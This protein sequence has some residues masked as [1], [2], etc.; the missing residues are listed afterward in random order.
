MINNYTKRLF[1]NCFPIKAGFLWILLFLFVNA[2][3][4][5]FT[6]SEID[7]RIKQYHGLKQDTGLVNLQLQLSELYL[8]RRGEAKNN[9][10]SAFKISSQ[11]LQLCEEL[12]YTQGEQQA[13][14]LLGKVYIKQHDEEAVEKL[15]KISNPVNQVRIM[16]QMIEYNTAFEGADASILTIATFFAK[17]SLAICDSLKLAELRPNVLLQLANINYYQH[18]IEN[19]RAYYLEALSELKKMNLAEG[20]AELFSQMSTYIKLSQDAQLIKEME[21]C[22]E[23][24]KSAY[25]ESAN[26]DTASRILNLLVAGYDQLSYFNL[27]KGRSNQALGYSLDMAKLIEKN[28]NPFLIEVPYQTIGKIYF[29]MGQMQQSVEYTKMAYNIVRQKGE[30]LDGSAVKTMTKA[31]IAS[32]KPKEALS[33][34]QQLLFD[35]GYDDI[36]NKKLIAESIGNCY[37]AMKEYDKAEKYYLESLEGAKKLGREQLFVSYVPLG[38]LYIQTKQYRKARFYLNALLDTGTETVP[39]FVKRDAHLMLF[40]ADSAAGDFLAAIKHLR[41]QQ[42]INDSIFN[43]RRDA[44]LEELRVQYDT[45]KKDKGIRLL[46]KKDELQTANLKQAVFSRNV[47]I[48]AMIGLILILMLLYHRYRFKQKTNRLLEEKQAEINA[49]NQ[50]LKKLVEEKE[51]LIKEIHHRVKNNLQIVISL[52]STQSKYLD[53]ND[54][55]SAIKESL[56]RMQAISLIHQKLYRSDDVALIQ[57]NE[58]INE[59]VFNI[60]NSFDN[61]SNIRIN[62]HADPVDLD[63]AQA[64]PIGLILNEAITNS[65]KYAFVNKDEGNIAI[66][67]HRAA[68]EKVE[69]IIEDDGIGFSHEMDIEKINSMGLRLMNGLTKQT[70]GTINIQSKNGV[71]IHV[72]FE[73]DTNL[74]T[75]L[76]KTNAKSN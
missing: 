35:G 76:E 66:R 7:N 53:N 29:E 55:V 60:Q 1:N 11:A 13:I 23:E 15:I 21:Q 36:R 48:S 65:M 24:V 12:H 44:Q 45:E 38:K 20:Q 75:I 51:W 33:F 73:P 69:L 63:R 18:Q 39:L 22:G 37:F 72:V 8:S 4:Q 67:L 57:M 41:K 2:R 32:G 17:R 16:V 49:Q 3:A 5:H 52:L 30:I 25:L 9:L 40:Q 31:Y 70:G 46:T 54:A 10:D 19:G 50:S 64:I 14:L 47:F 42:V 59:L 71:K 26:T 62:V 43:Q 58:Y 74:K 56:D 6:I 61:R 68:N 28:N 27:Y 34:L